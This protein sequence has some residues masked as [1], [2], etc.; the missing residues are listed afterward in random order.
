MTTQ[1]TPVLEN[2]IDNILQ[3]VIQIKTFYEAQ[4]IRVSAVERIAKENKE[5]LKGNGKLGLE[6]KVALLEE[7]SA[8]KTEFAILKESVNRINW[9][10]SFII[11]AILGDVI[12]RVLQ[13]V[14][15]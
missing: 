3:T 15:K 4:E 7:N 13:S 11:L 2:K 10:G 14:S 6:T 8:P 5:A 12:S 9:V 1:K